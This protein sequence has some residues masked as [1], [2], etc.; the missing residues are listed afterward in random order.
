M[1]Q[2]STS[3]FIFPFDQK[4]EPQQLPSSSNITLFLEKKVGRKRTKDSVPNNNAWMYLEDYGPLNP[5]QLGGSRVPK[6]NLSYNLHKKPRL[7]M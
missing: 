4:H 1:F 6:S 5:L 7:H 2:S 3:E